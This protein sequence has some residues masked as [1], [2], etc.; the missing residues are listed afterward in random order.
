MASQ[1]NIQ[2]VS[3]SPIITFTEFVL[4]HGRTREQY[5]EVAADVADKARTIV[6]RGFRFEC[7]LLRTGQ[8]SLTITDPEEGDAD[9]RVVPN[10]PGVR[11][12]V[13]D[14]VRRFGEAA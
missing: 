10:G 6:A 4:P 8:V 1:P 5:I 11:D 2:T 14:L 9:I 13:E 3:E 7:E 12:A